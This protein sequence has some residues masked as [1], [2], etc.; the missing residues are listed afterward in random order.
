MSYMLDAFNTL[1]FSAVYLTIIKIISLVEFFLIFFLSYSILLLLIIL[2]IVINNNNNN[3]RVLC[4]SV[5]II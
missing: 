2:L 4:H 3:E 5:V 1:I